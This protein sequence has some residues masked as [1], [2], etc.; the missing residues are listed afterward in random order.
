[1][2]SPA[3]QNVSGVATYNPA[4][5]KIIRRALRI[6]A[7]I[8]DEEEP[9]DAMMADGLEGLQSLMKELEATGIHVWTEEEAILFLQQYQVRYLLGGPPDN[10]SPDHCS[11]ANDWELS[12]LTSAV[13][14]GQTAIPVLD[15]TGMAKGDYFA[16]VTNTGAAFWTTIAS[17]PVAN[18][19][20]IVDPVPA[21]GTSNANNF[22]F[23]YTTN[24][25]RPLRIP[26]SRRLQYSTSQLPGNGIITQ[27]SPMMSRQQY[28]NLPNPTNPGIPTQCFYTPAR[29]QGEFYVW[30]APPDATNGVRFTYY[31][32]IYD[33]LSI[34]NTADLPQEWNSALNWNL[35]E[36]LKLDY[37]V[38]Q[39][40]SAVIAEKAKMKLELV[41]G[42]DREPESIYMGRNSKYSRG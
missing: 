36:E 35:A 22:V 37:S 29:D 2:T 17:N 21:T 24:I 3:D 7:V 10:P 39:A 28:F 6:M 19:V 9:T 11:D 40:R 41:M 27:M 31:R 14:P 25:L 12:S 20:T 1:M 34:D 26:F 42:W 15:A 38:S 32:P 8:D 33:F 16:I 23:A 4:A 18:V 30:N 5:T 13:V